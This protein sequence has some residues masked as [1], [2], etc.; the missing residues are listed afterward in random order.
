MKVLVFGFGMGP[1][2]LKPLIEKCRIE[3]PEV[4]FSVILSSSHHLELMIGLLGDDKTLC[5]NRLLPKYKDKKIDLSNLSNYPDNLYKNIESKKKTMKKRKANKQINIA[6]W[7]YFLLKEFILNIGPDHILY[8]QAP[9]NMESMIIG[10]LAEELNI[11]L[12]TPHHTRH[13]GLSFFSSEKLAILPS[14]A[15]VQQLDVEKANDFLEKFRAGRILPSYNAYSL[16]ES[17]KRLNPIPYEKKGKIDRLM[18]GVLR[19]FSESQSR[20]WANLKISLLNNWFPWVRDTRGALRKHFSKNL[21]NCPSIDALPNNYIYYPIQF[22]PESSINIPAPYFIDQLRVIDAIRMAMPS[23]LLL[24][25]KEHPDCITLRPPGF[26]NS[27][28]HKAGVLVVK[29]D[30]DSKELI[31]K[32]KLVISVTGTAAL[33]AFF[34]GKASLVMGP[35]F[36]AECLGGVCSIAE[37]PKRINDSLVKHVTKDEIIKFLSQVY[38]VSSDFLANTPG[39]PPCEIMSFENLDSFWEAFIKHTGR[40]K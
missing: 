20:E 31:I 14:S 40:G 24:V 18:A 8:L 29:H 25:V 4:D 6:Y 23:D 38:A 7:T 5:L 28:L 37:L 13:I 39:E 3:N 36:F 22:S 35:T 11:P 21:F 1:F 26:V 32:S 9:E 33:E 2:F 15:H 27:L 30:V 34:Y 17:T 12:A 16:T 10:G 19:Y